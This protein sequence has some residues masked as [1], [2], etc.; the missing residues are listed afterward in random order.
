MKEKVYRVQAPA[1]HEHELPGA[2]TR[3]D[4]G[5][6]EF[7]SEREALELA[8]VLNAQKA[9]GRDNWRSVCVRLGYIG[10]PA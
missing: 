6:H 10:G 8:E 2:A 4:G 1:R 7:D 5:H 3:P 9:Q